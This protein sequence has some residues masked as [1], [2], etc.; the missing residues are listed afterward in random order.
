MSDA[1]RSPAYVNVTGTDGY[2][3]LAYVSRSLPEGLGYGLNAN[4]LFGQHMFQLKILQR[5]GIDQAN[6]KMPHPR[7]C[8]VPTAACVGCHGGDHRRAELVSLGCTAVL[9]GNP[10]ADAV[11][12]KAIYFLASNGCGITSRGDRIITE[13]LERRHLLPVALDASNAAEFATVLQRRGQRALLIGHFS[14]HKLSKSL[15]LKHPTGCLLYT[16]P[17]PRDRG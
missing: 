1:V 15:I 8:Y 2:D 12:A 5:L 6:A 4:P 10:R 13:A 16:S 3:Y 17:S 7:M 14:P 9:A 11:Q